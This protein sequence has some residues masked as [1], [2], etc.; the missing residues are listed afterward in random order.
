M[1][2]R[3]VE[4]HCKFLNLIDNTISDSEKKNI[5]YKVKMNKSSKDTMKLKTR[6]CILTNSKE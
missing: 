5:I 6:S 2:S 4:I 3:P 1:G